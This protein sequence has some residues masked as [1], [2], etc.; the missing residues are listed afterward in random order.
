MNKNPHILLCF[1]ARERECWEEKFKSYQQNFVELVGGNI[2]PMFE[3]AL[4]DIF[5]EQVKNN[6]AIV[7]YGGDDDMLYYRLQQYDLPEIWQNKIIAGSSAGSDVLTKHYWTCDLRQC[8]DGFG[9]LP[10][11]FI[12]HYKSEYGSNDTRGPI[13]WKKAYEELAEY[14][15]KSLPIYALEEGDFII[16]EK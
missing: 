9:I 3:L 14:G 16:F 6:D 8:A 2:E 1:F 13:D 11:K 5:T 12:P 7:I 10:I 15:D 4:P